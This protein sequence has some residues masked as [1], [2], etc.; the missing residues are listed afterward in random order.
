MEKS[1]WASDENPY[2]HV[3]HKQPNRLCGQQKVCPSLNVFSSQIFMFNFRVCIQLQK[4]S[5]LC[6]TTE[7][8]IV[9]WAASNL[10]SKVE[11]GTLFM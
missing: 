3:L 11:S 2:L 4:Q 9:D 6:G 10:E 1:H 8:R 5:V 7:R